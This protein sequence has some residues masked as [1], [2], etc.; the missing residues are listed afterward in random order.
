MSDN[1]FTSTFGSFVCGGDF[2]ETKPDYRG[3]VFK[4]RVKY[5][6]CRDSPDERQDGFWPSRD[7]QA[8]GY[9]RPENFD[10]EQAK[11]EKVMAAWNNDRWWYCGIV[12]SIHVD[13]L[14]EEVL[15]DNFAASLW[16]I[17]A[18]YPDSDNSY[19]TDVANELLD[20]AQGIADGLVDKIINRITAA[21]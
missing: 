21:A 16:G 3:V 15:L 13:L 17:E 12:I 19:L 10:A 7:P 18:N 5:D 9:V 8:A 20:E 6:D 4:A 2:I 1:N 14:G 11:A